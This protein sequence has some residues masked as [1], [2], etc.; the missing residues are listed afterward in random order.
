MMEIH[1]QP[2]SVI[3]I[4]ATECKEPFAIHVIM[5]PFRQDGRAMM[6]IINVLEADIV[7]VVMTIL[8]V[9]KMCLPLFVRLLQNNAQ[10]ID[11]IPLQGLVILRV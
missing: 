3:D 5:H 2:I 9:F 7:P 10:R 11:V 8:I 4:N 6:I 1:A